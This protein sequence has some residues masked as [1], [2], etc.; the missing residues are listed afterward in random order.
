MA[1]KAFTN[2]IRPEFGLPWQR[3]FEDPGEYENWTDEDVV[4]DA[5]NKALVER[6]G[7]IDPIQFGWTLESWREVLE[8]W[9]AYGTHCIFGGNRASKSVFCARLMVHLLQTIPEC[10]LR[11]YHVNEEKSIAEQQAHIW[12]ALPERFKNLPKRKGTAHSI[13]YTQQNGFV[14]GKLIVPPL[15][16]CRRGGELIFGTY[17][18]YQNDPQ[19]VEGWWAHAIWG[20][21]EMPLK[22]YERLLTRLYDTRGRLVLSFTTIQ[23]WSPLVAD[24]IGKVKTLRKRKSELLRREIPVAQESLSRKSTRIYYFWTQDNPW[25]P[26]DTID[27]LRGRPVEEILS[28]AHGIPTKP[29]LSKFPKFDDTIHVI[30][31]DSLPWLRPRKDDE[32]EMEFTRYHVIDPSGRKPWAMLWAAV[33]AAGKIYIYREYPDIGYGSW[34][35]Q[36]EKPEGKAGPAQK[37]N[38]FGI[39]DYV[40]MIKTAE[41]TEEMFER[42]IDPRLGAATTQAKEGATSIISELDEAGLTYLAAP[43]L[44][45]DHG[46]SLINDR[47]SYDTN[48]PVSAMNSPHLFIS[49]RCENL[50]ECLKNYTGAGGNDE[51]WKDFIDCVRYLLENGADFV[52][53]SDLQGQGRTFSY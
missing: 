26:P 51:V 24:I 31:H 49:D 20:D 21:E 11:C 41:D 47:L 6:N 39:M 48:A 2:E 4:T 34:G 30:P 27:N 46:L 40:D 42:L 12:E 53:R 36:S 33:D 25:I 16:G 17:A 10:R 1:V 3:R 7:L 9:Q 32:P 5:E 22:M 18:Q 50:I 29:A 28:V 14:G 13:Q 52:S 44:H 19:C 45:I 43:G 15:P 23:G 37:P 8:N 35:E 38:G